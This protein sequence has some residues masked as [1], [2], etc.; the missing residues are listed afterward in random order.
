LKKKTLFTK[1]EEN[2]SI[3]QSKTLKKYFFWKFRERIYKG[4][5]K[6][7]RKR[8]RK[9]ERKKESKTF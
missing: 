1:N 5:R 2:T 6:K 9:K 7:E 8:E 4:E 3:K